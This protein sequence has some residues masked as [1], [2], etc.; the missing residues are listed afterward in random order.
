MN[1]RL[2]AVEGIDGSGK[3]QLVK[4]LVDK[5]R[6]EGRSVVAIETCEAETRPAYQMAL[7]SYSLDPLSPAYMF[8]FQFLHA[9]KAERVQRALDE[10]N[11]VVSDRWDLS[12]FAWHENVGFFRQEP[13][14]LRRDVSRL[15]FGGLQPA[16][17][18][19][20]DAD[21][22]TAIGR[23]IRRGESIDDV[24]RE[25]ELYT[26]IASSYRALARRHG[27]TQINAN[28]DFDRVA[29]MAWDLVQKTLE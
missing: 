3:S 2:I 21:V 15:A 29:A 1:N 20:L 13:G 9:H 26:M 11:F 19:Y 27:W 12:F 25:T 28:D 6:R 16:L 7:D 14:E 23:R 24:N 8:F 10:G 18:I 5:L 17:G 4:C 22:S